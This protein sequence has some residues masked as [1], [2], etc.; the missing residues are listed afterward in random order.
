MIKLGQAI[1]SLLSSATGVTQ[2]VGLHI[3]PII[4]PQVINLPCV[5]YERQS[6]D[7]LSKDGHGIYDSEVFLTIISTSYSNSIDIAQACHDALAEYSG[8]AGGCNIIKCRFQ[9]INENYVEEVF[10]QRMSFS[11]KS[12]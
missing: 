3:F 11:I 8:T 4:V 1:Y 5:V 2:Y 9:S 6:S 7:Q 10:M 12:R